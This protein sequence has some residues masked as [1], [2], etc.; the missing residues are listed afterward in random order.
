MSSGH[1]IENIKEIHLFIKYQMQNI[2]K[3]AQALKLLD[4][5]SLSDD[6]EKK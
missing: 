3:I 5:F 1:R 2:K 4:K 6:I